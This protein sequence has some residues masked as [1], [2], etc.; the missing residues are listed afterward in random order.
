MRTLT[1]LS[2]GTENRLTFT[3]GGRTSYGE[4]E[5]RTRPYEFSTWG[6]QS[7]HH[8][9]PSTIDP[10]SVPTFY[11]GVGDTTGHRPTRRVDSRSQ[12]E[13]CKLQISHI[14]IAL[15]GLKS[16][17]AFVY[18]VSPELADEIFPVMASFFSKIEV[19]K[20]ERGEHEYL[21]R[22]LGGMRGTEQMICV[23]E[24]RAVCVGLNIQR[25]ETL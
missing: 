20:K 25:E 22:A 18:P 9:P 10:G 3:Q 11:P 1:S 8:V 6:A 12:T 7:Q 19:L 5:I 4:A 24:A 15:Q 2:M 13:R 23:R 17:F 14:E 21:L 16:T